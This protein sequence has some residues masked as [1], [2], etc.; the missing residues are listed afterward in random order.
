[1]GNGM[2]SGE[3][4]AIRAIENA[5]KSPLLNSNDITGA[6]SILINISTGYG[7]MNLPWTNSGR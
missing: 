7:N 2:A 1:M 3:N 6:Q 4:R 5:L